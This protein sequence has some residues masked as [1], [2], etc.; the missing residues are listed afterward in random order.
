MILKCY[1]LYNTAKGRTIL[2]ILQDPGPN[3]LIDIPQEPGGYTYSRSHVFSCFILCDL[4]SSH[5]FPNAVFALWN[6]N[7]LGI[8][9]ALILLPFI[10][11]L[12]ILSEFGA[13]KL[14]E[15]WFQYLDCGVL[16]V[17]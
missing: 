4:R 6:S 10:K 13:R 14:S 9:I 2:P 11:A 15:L 7:S 1:K 16:D 12:A 8:Q 17:L 3:Y 5:A